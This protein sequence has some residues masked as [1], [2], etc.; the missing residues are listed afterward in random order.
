MASLVFTVLLPLT[1]GLVMFGLGLTLTV[2]D[3]ARVLKYP[4]AAA[5]ALTCQIV[6]LPAVCFGLV[7]A[8]QLQ[9]AL[10][11]GVMLLVAA[12]GGITANL[13]SHLAGGDVALNITLTAI[14]SLLAAFTLPVVVAL[15][16]FRFLGDEASIGLQFGKFV[17]VLAIVLIP[18]AIGVWTRHRFSAWADRMRQPVKI[19]SMSVLALVTLGALAQSFDVLTANVGRLGGIALLLCT[20]SLTIGY[21]VARLFRV[22]RRQSIASAMEIGLHNST[23][24][25][26]VGVSVI[27]EEVMA[28]P[29]AVYGVLMFVPAG[30]AA[31]LFSRHADPLDAPA[32]VQG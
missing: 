24:A 1:L 27:G 22:S 30:L 29:A 32:P 16:T 17:Q 20:L 5:V 12:P 9:G 26:I 18:V 10:A 11:V 7:L 14:N 28:V 2:A 6:L 15:A 4:K 8:F 31:Y 25:I 3:F 19:A 23:L 21:V 13:F